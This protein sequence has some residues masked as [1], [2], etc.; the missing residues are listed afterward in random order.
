MWQTCA[1]AGLTGMRDGRQ[2]V[3]HG[4]PLLPIYRPSFLSSIGMIYP[5]HEIIAE[6]RRPDESARLAHACHVFVDRSSRRTY[7]IP[8]RASAAS[9]LAIRLLPI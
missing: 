1:D 5:S 2:L 3:H 6:R 4:L 7:M 8:L 9:P